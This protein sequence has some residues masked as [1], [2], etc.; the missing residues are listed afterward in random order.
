MEKPDSWWLRIKRP[1]E[2]TIVIFS[3]VLVFV[4]V[5]LIIIGY[6]LKWGWTG[7]G[8]KTLWDWLQLLI[9]PVVL[10]VGG[11]LFNF[12]TS[13]NERQAAAKRDQNEREIASD[14]QREEALQSYIDK[15]SELLLEKQL[16]ESQPEDEVRTIARVRTLTTLPRLDETRKRS[17]LQFLHESRLIDKDKNIVSLSAADLSGAGLSEANLTRANLSKAKLSKASLSKANL[18]KADLSEVD[19]YGASLDGADLSEASLYGADLRRADL[20][21]ADLYGAD[22]FEADLSEASLYGADLSEARLNGANLRGADLSKA[23]L[24]RADL[25]RANLDG[26]KVTQEQIHQARLL[27]NTTMPDGSKHS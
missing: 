9:I 1:L 21:K 2:I 23:D 5:I 18:S 22:L 12:T 13:R 11:Y 15:I 6:L 20:N 26:A 14:N 10:A 25:G 7:L 24:N 3:L 8:Q 17:I 27:Q 16:R 4:L 19:L